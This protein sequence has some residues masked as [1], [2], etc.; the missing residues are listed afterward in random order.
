MIE[1]LGFYWNFYTHFTAI[2]TNAGTVIFIW[3]KAED[4]FDFH[5]CPCQSRKKQIVMGFPQ[6]FRGLDRS[7]CSAMDVPYWAKPDPRFRSISASCWGDFSQVNV[8][9]ASLNVETVTIFLFPGKWSNF[10]FSLT[11]N[12]YETRVL[13][14]YSRLI[15]YFTGIQDNGDRI[16]EL[17]EGLFCAYKI[18]CSRRRFQEMAKQVCW[19]SSRLE[20]Q[21]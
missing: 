11:Q 7:C 19:R 18:R 5:L 1:T 3:T 9:A 12:R 13:H 20:R 15:S 14:S 8:C 17:A 16:F 2:L 21:V 10:L 4:G 6:E